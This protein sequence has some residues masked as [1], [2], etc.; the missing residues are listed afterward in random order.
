MSIRAKHYNSGNGR[1]RVKRN[2]DAEL[3]AYLAIREGH[4]TEM[5]DRALCRGIPAVRA[6]ETRVSPRWKLSD[7]RLTGED[8][9]TVKDAAGNEVTVAKRTRTRSRRTTVVSHKAEMLALDHR[10]LM[11]MSSNHENDV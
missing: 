4:P 3:D 8:Y 6:T 2:P 5:S 1:P 7:K 9:G 11:S 10:L